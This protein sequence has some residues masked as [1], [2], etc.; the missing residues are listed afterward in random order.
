MADHIEG[1]PRRPAFALRGVGKQYGQFFACRNVEFEI[2][3]GD[4]IGLTGENGAGKSTSMKCLAGWVAPTEGHIECDGKVVSFSGPRDA[5]RQGIAVIPQELDLFPELP[6][7]E[8]IFIGSRWPRSR[9]GFHNR[10]AMKRHAEEILRSLGANFDASLLVKALSPADQKL[11]EIARALSRKARLLIMDEP[12]AALTELESGRLFGVIKQLQKQ[13]TAIVHITH[14]LDEVFEH[15]NRIVVL[16]DGSVVSAGKTSDFDTKSLIQHMVGR[17]VSRLYERKSRQVAGE[18]VLETI[19]LSRKGLFKDV[20]LQVRRGEILGLA[21]LIGAGR[22]DFALS[23][24]GLH[25]P[26]G[27]AIRLHGEKV[28]LASIAHA[29]KLGIAYLPEER[30][31][32]GLHLSYPAS[33]NM[34]FAALRLF[35]RYG[36]VNRESER[37]F[38]REQAQRFRIKMESPDVAVGSLSGGNQQKVLLAKILA[39]NPDLIILDEPTRGVDIGAKSEIYALIEKLVENGRAIIL[40]SSDMEEVICLSDHIA[41]FYQGQVTK[42]FDQQDFSPLAIGHAVSGQVEGA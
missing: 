1:V 41:T 22:T 11:V 32:Q 15:C 24:A 37:T 27:G 10:T 12:T 4:A 38:S 2:F 30:R 35:S 6:I 34:T 20:S 36:I 21:G 26:D 33:W 18:I 9:L 16:R 14:R 40:I 7:Y 3:P 42:I 31:T 39:G 13:G 17:P 23:I 28:R 8:N 5:E 25:R 29:L 19:D